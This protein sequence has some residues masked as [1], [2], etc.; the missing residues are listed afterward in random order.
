M[1][2]GGLLCIEDVRAMLRGRLRRYRSLAQMAGT[3]GIHSTNLSQ[4]MRG[5][6]PPCRLTL[7]YLGVKR[8]VRYIAG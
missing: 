4:M 1:D 6:R 3:I 2:G 5:Y 8:V 7:K